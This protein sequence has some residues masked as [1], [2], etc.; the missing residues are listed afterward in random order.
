MNKGTSVLLASF[1]TQYRLKDR[2]RDLWEE[3]DTV[4]RTGHNGSRT[5]R[6]LARAEQRSG[7][8]AVTLHRVLWSQRQGN[9]GRME[10]LKGPESGTR[11]GLASCGR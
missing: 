9:M 8:W 6:K 10:H 11:A 3:L 1:W 4:D 7:S 2:S 5:A